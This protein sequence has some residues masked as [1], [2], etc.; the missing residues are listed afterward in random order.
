MYKTYHKFIK[1]EINN[2]NIKERTIVCLAQNNQTICTKKSNHVLF[3]NCID[4]N[5]FAIDWGNN[6]VS[7]FEEYKNA[8]KG[9]KISRGQ[10]ISLKFR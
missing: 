1:S 4:N 8:L 3:Y 10:K 5:I 2:T 6:Y 7:T 9:E